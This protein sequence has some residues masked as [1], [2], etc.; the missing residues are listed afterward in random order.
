MTESYSSHQ[1]HNDGD[2]C[3]L[4]IT[5]PH[6][7]CEEAPICNIGVDIQQVN[8]TIFHIVEKVFAKPLKGLEFLALL[9]T[10]A[11]VKQEALPTSSTQ[12]P[13]AFAVVSLQNIRELAQRIHWGYDTTHKYVVTF[14]A[15]DLLIKRR[16]SDRIELLFPLQHYDPPSSLHELDRLLTK[17]RPK[18]QQFAKRV[19]ERCLIYD[20]VAISTTA[21]TSGS[22]ITPPS[23]EQELLTRLHNILR[24]ENIDVER[25]QRLVMRI[26]S[27][28]IGKLLTYPSAQVSSSKQGRL[29]APGVQSKVNELESTT[30]GRLFPEVSSSDKLESTTKVDSAPLPATKEE[31]E[32]PFAVDSSLSQIDSK[33][34]KSTF[35][36]DSPPPH[37]TKQ[38]ES[39]FVVD[40]SKAPQ[41]CAPSESTPKGDSSIQMTPAE[42][43]SLLSSRLS[44]EKTAESAPESTLHRQGDSRKSPY[45]AQKQKTSKKPSMIGALIPRSPIHSTFLKSTH[46]KAVDSQPEQVDSFP[47]R[48]DSLETEEMAVVDSFPTQVDFDTPMPES[49]ESLPTLVDLP[50]EP[51]S[52]ADRELESTKIKSTAQNI[53]SVDSEAQTGKMLVDLNFYSQ[54]FA[55]LYVTL[56]VSKLFNNILNKNNTNVTLRME[57]QKFFAEIFDEGRQQASKYNSLFEE[58]DT[59]TIVA[60]FI[61]SLQCMLAASGH[62][63]KKPGAFFTSNCTKIWN[64]QLVVSQ[65]DI[66]FLKQFTCEQMYDCL[67][68]PRNNTRRGSLFQHPNQQQLPMQS[69]HTQVRQN[70]QTRFRTKFAKGNLYVPGASRKNLNKH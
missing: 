30:E 25:R 67:I 2:G 58:M 38:Q 22:S 62:S 65:A 9:L 21:L 49:L 64:K 4:P 56:D 14:C 26:S 55:E 35:T 20:V 53:P 41:E 39:T 33:N 69:D 61:Y 63:I 37:M 51:A 5:S 44:P 32:S 42:K 46:S 66:D 34:E 45:P 57:L 50:I 1:P 3:T 52:Q 36:V 59:T 6:S 54:E 18:V 60:G 16:S 28:I 24:T 29:A 8:P 68:N 47:S 7:H 13:I 40:S 19:R 11:V 23:P 12:T 31:E 10:Q 17:S 48:V 70:G 15:L 27:E 43:E